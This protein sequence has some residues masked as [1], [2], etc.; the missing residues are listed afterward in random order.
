MENLQ[1]I[2]S[3][4]IIAAGLIFMFFGVIGLF[5]FK[6][7]YS[8]LLATSKI[9][10]VGV[11]TLII[12]LAVRNGISF[13]SGKILLLAVIMMIFNPLIAHVLARSAYLSGHETDNEKPDKPE[14]GA[15]T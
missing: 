12:G 13:F 3:N 4:I 5:K 1:E 7:F 14:E 11:I 8:R 6:N 9:D 10:T 2:I 15:S